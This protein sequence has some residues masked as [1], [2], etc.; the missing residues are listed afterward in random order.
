DGVIVYVL[1][2]RTRN[3]MSVDG[4]DPKQRRNFRTSPYIY[5]Q[6]DKAAA[7]WAY[8]NGAFSCRLPWKDPR[9]NKAGLKDFGIYGS[10]F[11]IPLGERERRFGS[12]IAWYSSKEC[13]VQ[14]L[15]E[16]QAILEEIVRHATNPLRLALS[17][18]K[19]ELQDH[20]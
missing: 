15:Q 7:T 16:T 8:S 1:V 5:R 6:E 11:A 9:V 18:R 10:L 13:S 4:N 19:A 20:V 2:P 3:L 17:T 12:V 14:E